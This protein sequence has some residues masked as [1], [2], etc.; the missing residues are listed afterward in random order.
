MEAYAPLYPQAKWFLTVSAIA[1]VV[2]LAVPLAVANR[3]VEALVHREILSQELQVAYD[4]QMGLLPEAPNIKGL[5]LAGKCLTA[6]SVGGDYYNYLWLDKGETQLAIIVGD[7]AGHDM[8]AA[9][10]A[11]MF[12]GMLEYAIQEQTPGAMLCTLNEILCR[13]LHLTPFISCCNRPRA[14]DASLVRSRPPRDISLPQS[15][16][17]AST[18]IDGQLSVG[19][20]LKEVEL[21]LGDT[22]IF[23]TDGLVE[24]CNRQEEMY[25]YARME[26]S[27]LRSCQDNVSSIG[28]INRMVG[29]AHRFMG[30]QE[31]ADDITLVIAKVTG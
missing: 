20:I 12:S 19:G 23:H 11:V 3:V 15:D 7:V 22:L 1:F 28:G 13:R 16:R 6:N 31:Q 26:K 30:S 27:V 29:D 5:D 21:S 9:I 2:I 17:H 8:S 14:E 24:A 10:P 25:G 4:T 18:V